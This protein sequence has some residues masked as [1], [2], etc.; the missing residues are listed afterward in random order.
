MSQ[1]SEP[2]WE[3]VHAPLAR[4]ASERPDASFLLSDTG[5]T[6][7][8]A[9]RWVA[10]VASQHLQR[11]AGERVA[12]WLDKGNGYAAGILAALHAGCTYVPIDGAQP[13]P[14][15]G[16]ILA[17]AAASAVIADYSHACALLEQGLPP[18][19]RQLLLLSDMPPP[20]VPAGLEVIQLGVRLDT[21]PAGELAAGADVDPASIAAIL[22]TS[23]STGV[24][25]GVQL[26]HLNL[27]NFVRWCVQEFALG[28]A[29]RLFNLASF[30]FDLS[31]FDL[32]ATLQAGASLYVSSERET[33]QPATVADLLRSQRITVMYGVP[34][35]YALL[36]RIEAWA[37]AHPTSAALALRCVLFAGEVMPKP[38]LKLMAAGLPAGCSF[39]NLYG[40]TETNV[41]LYHRVSA[42]DLASDGPLP[43]GTPIHGA[44]VWLVDDRGRLVT[45][46]G[47][48]GE[49]WVAGRCV[50][51]GYWRRKDPKNADN[52][53][54]GMHATG[55]YGEW[56]AGRLLYRGRKDRM[57]KLNGYRVELG[58]IESALARHPLVHEVAVLVDPAPTPRLLAFYVTSDPGQRLSSLELKAF[59]AQHLPKYM[60]P[61]VLTQ[62]AGLPKN[63]NGKIDYRSLR[64][65]PE[66][67]VA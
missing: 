27:S 53:A 52:H 3:P 19:V 24:P 25:K 1:A 8:Q 29:D 5:L 40:P 43:I 18:G 67:A 28:D 20:Q 46:E 48:L 44:N 33:G 14:R 45:E 42:Q 51:P 21:A 4:H 63:A 13:A 12:L 34:S 32:F 2:A 11:F 16:M 23:G 47:T 37:S 60:I 66:Q 56:L 49:V 36:N 61:H 65:E 31:T 38:Q 62:Q 54:R 58:E 35:L 7:A 64:Q 22:Y 55:D 17:D 30:N 50:T 10:H 6:Y 9:A 15:A 59:C 39:Y 57:L 41:C 26:S